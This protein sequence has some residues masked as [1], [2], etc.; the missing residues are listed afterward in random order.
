V[1][2]FLKPNVKFEKTEGDDRYGKFVMEPLQRGYGA[3]IGNS[4][5]RIMLSSMAGSSVSNVRIDGVLHEFCAINGVRDDVTDI[6]MNLK[7]ITVRSLVD[8]P[9]HIKLEANGIGKVTAKNFVENTNVE[10]IDPDST[11]LK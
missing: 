9:V 11:L 5:R 7:N 6:V 4:L 10:I 2:E 8:E 1:I 3:T